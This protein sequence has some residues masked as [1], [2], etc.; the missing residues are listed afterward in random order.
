MR[1]GIL[2]GVPVLVGV[3]CAW[4]LAPTPL[5]VAQKADPMPAQKRKE[6]ELRIIRVGNTFQGVRFKTATGEAWMMVGD[7][8]EKLAES[9]PVPAG[10]YDITL[11]TDDTNWM[12][13]RID[14]ATG[15][16]WQLRNNKWV[17]VKE[18]DDKGA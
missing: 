13:F 18:P 3:V 7:K 6:H 16:T 9:G 12:A 8:F 1:R 4:G 5:A 17:K 11:V 14:H 2:L 10:D 15:A